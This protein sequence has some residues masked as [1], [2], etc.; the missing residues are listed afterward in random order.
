VHLEFDEPRWIFD[1]TERETSLCMKR[2]TPLRPATKIAEGDQDMSDPKPD[3]E[4]KHSISNGPNARPRDEPIGQSSE[5]EPDD[6]SK[7]VE[8]SPEEEK[9]IADKIL[10]R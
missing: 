5:G 10:D 6:S 7:A 4:F 3:R 2:A 9:R 8:I 1:R